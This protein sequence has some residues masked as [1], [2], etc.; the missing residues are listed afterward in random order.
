[1]GEH[2]VERL[3]AGVAGA[4]RGS[5]PSARFAYYART[6]ESMQQA[7]VSAPAGS[8]SRTGPSSPGISIGAAGVAAGEACFTTAMTGYEESVT[9]PSY[10]AQVLCFAY[11]L[12]G[13]YGV[14][15]SR[16]ESERVQCEGVVMRDVAA[17][18]RRLAARA[19]RRRAQR[20]RHAH[21]RAQDPRRR[22][23]ALRARRGAR[24]GAA[25]ARARR[26]ADR[27]PAARPAGRRDRALLA[28][29][30]ARASSSS[31][32]ARSA[33]SR[34]GS[35][36]RGSRPTS[37][38]GTWEADAILEAGPR[39]VLIA[40]GPGDPAVLTDAGRDDPRAAR[41]GARSSA[42][43]SATSCSASRSATR[44][45]SSPS[46]TAAP[47]TRSATLAT[48]RVLVTV[49]NHG[50]AVIADGD[51]SHVSLNDGTCEGLAGDG[52]ESVQFHPEASPGP[53]RRAPLLR[54]PGRDVPKRTDL[55]SILILGSGPIRI[56]QALRVRLLRR[57]GLP[58]AAA[59][60][61]PRRARQLEPGHDHDRP[62]VGRRDLP[63]AA[64]RR[65]GRRGDRA[66]AARRDPADARRADGAQ[67]R[68]RAGAAR[69]RA[70]RRRPGG[71]QPRRGPR[72]LP[73]RRCTAS[74]SR[75]RAA[76]SPTRPRS[77]FPLPAIVRPAFTLGGTGGGV[78]CSAEE[79]RARRRPRARGEPGRPG[80]RRGVPAPA[81]R[82]TSSR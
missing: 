3:L 13:T 31:T 7:R 60:G 46:A 17:R 36:T 19:G 2:P 26:A 65:D 57:S 40:N 39:A 32:S 82:S 29:A 51:V 81:G 59:R 72:A 45:S 61:L 56:G 77:T 48:G 52:F 78:A 80:A 50:F 21:A 16:M 34:A 73:R 53:A 38:P 64:R 8:S 54:P 22:R 37:C 66:R 58:R 10:V 4:T 5:P 62:R 9:D 70:D 76:S 27:R 25:R 12:I 69:G 63:R 74:A 11:P 6:M 55:R 44:P 24:R 18:V 30:P 79:L 14:D 75:R 67:P 33:R 47:T 28:S 1:M 35:P 71:D 15:E 23:P 20:A 49:Q 42:S 41:A 68:R 43:A